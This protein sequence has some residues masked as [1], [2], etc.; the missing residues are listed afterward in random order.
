M[1]QFRRF[2]ILAILLLNT[3]TLNVFSV[4]WLNLLHG[5]MPKL[6]QDDP[7]AGKAI[8]FMFIPFFNIYWIFFTLTR[9]VKRIDEQRAMRGL[10]PSAAA[11]PAIMVCV[12]T[13]LS[14][15][16][17]LGIVTALLNYMIV[18]PLLATLVQKSI[19]SLVEV[20]AQPAPVPPEAHRRA[21]MRAKKEAFDA[22]GW[23]S[24]VLGGLWLLLM[25][26]MFFSSPGPG[27][28]SASQ[29]SA[30]LISALVVGGPPL[31]VAAVLLFKSWKLQSELQVA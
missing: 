9:V 10:Q 21:E 19:T 6:R 31:V 1:H 22:W 15:I 16:P 18:V 14:C 24:L 27:D 30:A 11:V 13:V 5:K 23:L 2:S 26:A 4:V 29:Q 12:F 25:T 20:S 8:G 7:S 28:T 17:I 3:V